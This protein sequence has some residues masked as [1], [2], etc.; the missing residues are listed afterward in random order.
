LIKEEKERVSKS[1]NLIL[2]DNPILINRV[3]IKEYLKQE[4]DLKVIKNNLKYR[5]ILSI[6]KN[7]NLNSEFN[8]K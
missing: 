8:V 4:Q 7:N 1:K 5:S 2:S 3:C 6:L